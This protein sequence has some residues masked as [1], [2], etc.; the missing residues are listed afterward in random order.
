[1]VDLGFP[2]E[3]ASHK[4]QAN[5]TSML[6][7]LALICG[8]VA[9]S[10]SEAATQQAA[11]CALGHS[12]TDLVGRFAAE[13]NVYCLWQGTLKRDCYNLFALQPPPPPLGL[14]IKY[15]ALGYAT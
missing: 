8:L 2:R 11:D 9:A 3:S 14:D 13:E 12:L 7:V 5:W 1:M 6:P 10:S 15:H 4:S